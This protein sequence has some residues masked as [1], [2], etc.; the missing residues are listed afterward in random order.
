VTYR[1]KTIII[2]DD[3][4]VF[5]MYVAILL[6]RMGFQVIPVESGVEVMKTIKRTA[7]D[8]VILDIMMPELSGIEVLRFIRSETTTAHIPVIMASAVDERET[9]EECKRLGCA[10]YL[11]KPI[12]VEEL[13]N[14]LQDCIFSP[15][16]WRRK[17]LR[18]AHDEK[19][20]IT[21]EGF[22][23]EVFSEIISE[24]GIYL[25]RSDP[26]PA[27]SD[28]EIELSLDDGRLLRLRGTVIYV[29]GLYGDIF[30]VSPGMAVEFKDL[31][32]ET[33]LRLSKY[34]KPPNRR[35]KTRLFF[36][37]HKTL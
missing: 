27:G 13:H 25:R 30:K 2:V 4:K 36:L 14:V 16:G 18:V 3:S 17:H 33:S 9:I 10:G 8:L 20:F 6:K 37:I 24:G 34:V 19:L 7:P 21:H 1:P 26:F 5:L 31:D 28:V 22:R 11:K 23:Q 29:K 12:K 32:E 35:D 15:L